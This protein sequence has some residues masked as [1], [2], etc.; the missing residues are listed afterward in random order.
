MPYANV[1]KDKWDEMDR[2]VKEV[3]SDK[4]MQEKYPD[5]K[6][7]KGHAIAVC[8]SSIVGSKKVSKAVWSTAY[9][10]NLPD[11]AF[12]YVEPGEKDSEGK[13]TP[14]SKRHLPY[15]N[16]EGKVDP[17]HVRNALARLPQTNISADAKAKAKR[18]LVAAARG[19][20]IEVEEKT[21]RKEVN[22]VKKTDE[23]ELKATE[24]AEEVEAKTEADEV[25]AK[26]DEVVEEAEEVVEEAPEAE[27]EEAPE[28]EAEKADKPEAE[29]AVEK[30]EEPEAGDDEPEVVEKAEDEEPAE[31]GEAE[32]KLDVDALNKVL[33]S[34][35]E[36]TAKVNELSELVKQSPDEG[37]AATEDNPVDE[38]KA[39]ASKEEV[40]KVDKVESTPE[41]EEK[42]VE[43]KTEVT[44]ADDSSAADMLEKLS[45]SIDSLSERIEKL[46]SSPAPSRVVVS[47][48]FATKNKENVTDELEKVSARLQEISEIR[49]KTPVKYTE[50]L[51]DEALG[52]VKRKK[53]LQG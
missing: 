47:K 39:E 35:T 9:V 5:S 41:P 50:A 2:C 19:V 8:H 1:P 13:T 3:M 24:K 30:V 45:K 12:A 27:A 7:R 10:N 6:E 44:K 4:N 14:R 25:V 38:V 16:K 52:L 43:D 28:E 37:A 40:A 33:E 34:I 21:K 15:K 29:E 23:K 48:D 31:E 46:E 26:A 11:S 49:D 51:M 36:L 20:G 53:E 17:A 42:E 22:K 32:A 18:K